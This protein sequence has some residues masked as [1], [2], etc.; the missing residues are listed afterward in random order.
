MIA[1][2]SML[3]NSVSPLVFCCVDAIR[4][5]N[6]N[7]LLYT[8]GAEIADIKIKIRNLDS[9]LSITC[10]SIMEYLF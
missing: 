1:I 4:I 6:P 2:F 9:F 5:M 10:K 3:I 8:F 7:L